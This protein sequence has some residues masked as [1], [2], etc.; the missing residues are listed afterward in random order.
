MHHFHVTLLVPPNLRHPEATVRLRYLTALG[1]LNLT[2]SLALL[3]GYGRAC[4]ARDGV[5]GGE[6]YIVAM[7]EA[8]VHKDAG[9]IFPQHNVWFPR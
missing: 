2:A 9:P 5:D 6:A 4:S 1:I 8:S 3:E 7:P